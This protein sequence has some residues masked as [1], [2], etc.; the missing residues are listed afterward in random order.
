MIPETLLARDSYGLNLLVDELLA[1]LA[2]MVTVMAWFQ[3]L[4]RGR[5]I[6]KP[7]DLNMRRFVIPTLILDAS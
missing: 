2:V 4:L 5:S 1:R 3:S 6:L 7:S